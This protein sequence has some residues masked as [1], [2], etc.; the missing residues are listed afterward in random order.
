[1]DTKSINLGI[2]PAEELAYAR[3]FEDGRTGLAGLKGI[4]SEYTFDEAGA[5]LAGIKDGERD[6]LYIRDRTDGI[7]IDKLTEQD[8]I[9]T[10]A[11]EDDRH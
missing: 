8:I 11:K 6:F 2:S 7:F 1:M 10:W 5:Y 9:N 4:P 3:G